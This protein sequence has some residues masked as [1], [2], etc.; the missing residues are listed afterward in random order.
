MNPLA[1]LSL[2]LVLYGATWL[3]LGLVFGV[4]R[5]SCFW[6]AAAF[7]LLAVGCGVL[8]QGGSSHVAGALLPFVSA[9][10]V[11]G[12][13]ALMRGLAHMGRYPLSRWDTLV[14]LGLLVLLVLLRATQTEWIVARLALFSVAVG[15]TLLRSAWLL[16]R[17][18]SDAGYGRLFL[19]LGLF[20]VLAI[21]VLIS[22]R[23]L[24]VLWLPENAAEYLLLAD[25]SFMNLFVVTGFVV[26]MLFNLAMAVVVVGGLVRHLR[27]L[28]LTDALTQLANRRSLVPVLEREHSLFLRT[29]K[30]YSLLVLDLDHFKHI[31]DTHGHA[32]GD[33]VLRHVAATLQGCLRVSDMAA[34]VGGEEFTVL[35]PG[36]EATQAAEV[37]ERIRLQIM[38]APVPVGALRV[39]VTISIGVATATPADAL[40]R[41]VLA[42]AD[43][44][45]YRAK[46]LGRNRV[47]LAT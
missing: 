29:R 6:W 2:Q 45:L 38:N 18:L 12:F 20:P 4:R 1:L 15:W 25:S 31:N 10:A 44:A 37:A 41:D 9:M 24:A 16:Q 28:S 5:E 14:P 32:V 27:N 7:L 40:S 21:V 36:S 34:R 39:S 19:P 35:L 47:E 23:P 30:A 33:E 46:H 42:R 43:Q 26:L 13:Y 22:L 3:V 11:G 8:E 17:L